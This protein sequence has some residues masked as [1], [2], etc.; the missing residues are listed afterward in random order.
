MRNCL[1]RSICSYDQNT[2]DLRIS[3]KLRPKQRNVITKF[4]P[5]IAVAEGN[6]VF[7]TSDAT[8]SEKSWYFFDLW[9]VEDGKIVMHWD[10]VSPTP[11]EMACGNGKF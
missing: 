7:V 1:T 3:N 9:G 4:E 2:N 6:F 8:V 5:Q 11:T 10:V